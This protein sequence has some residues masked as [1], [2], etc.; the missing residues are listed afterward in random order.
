M[1]GSALMTRDVDVVCALDAEN[2][3]RIHTALDKLHPVHRMTPAKL[4]FTRDQAMSGGLKY[5][6]LT[7]DWGQLDCLGEVK[8]VGDYKACLGSSEI[9]EIDGQ[10]M[11]VLS[12]DA[13]IQAKRAMGRP[14]DLHAVLEL[15]AIRD[16]QRKSNS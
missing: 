10:S 5:L 8:G 14:R 7:T 1:H 2:L 12:I 13:L 3:V 15:E 6:Y 11:H 9:L 16:Q 4:P